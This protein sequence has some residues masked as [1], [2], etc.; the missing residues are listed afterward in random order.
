M[1]KHTRRTSL[2]SQ[3]QHHLQHEHLLAEELRTIFRID[4]V[5][6]RLARL[7]IVAVHLS[8]DGSS[9]RVAWATPVDDASVPEALERASGFIRARLA[10]SLNWKRTP[11]LSFT[12]LGVYAGGER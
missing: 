1:S 5:D 4:L 8:A 6:P 7:V 3:L 9:A 11:R 2:P 10:E 12:S